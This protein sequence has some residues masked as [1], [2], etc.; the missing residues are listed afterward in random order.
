MYTVLCKHSSQIKVFWNI[1]SPEWWNTQ[2]G[3]SFEWGNKFT[4]PLK[5]LAVIAGASTSSN[6]NVQLVYKILRST[7]AITFDPRELLPRFRKTDGWKWARAIIDAIE[8]AEKWE[9]K[10]V[11]FEKGEYSSVN[12]R[13]YEKFIQEHP[14]KLDFS[15]LDGFAKLYIESKDAKSFTAPTWVN[16]AAYMASK[17]WTIRINKDTDVFL[18]T[19]YTKTLDAQ[20]AK[21]EEIIKP[22]I[23]KLW[24]NS[25]QLKLL[26]EKNNLWWKN[27]KI[28]FN[29]FVWTLEIKNLED[30]KT[31]FKNIAEKLS[32]ESAQ[33]LE[34]W[35]QQLKDG[36]WA[37]LNATEIGIANDVT[38][39]WR[40]KSLD[41][42]NIK[43]WNQDEIQAALPRI[44]NKIKSIDASL[45]IETDPLKIAELKRRQS[46]LTGI[47]E[48]LVVKNEWLEKAKKAAEAKKVHTDAT[49]YTR[50]NPG[51]TTKNL[52]EKLQTEKWQ[53]GIEMAG[54]IGLARTEKDDAWKDLPKI[55]FEE[56]Q[57]LYLELEKKWTLTKEEEIRK[58]EYW[59]IIDAN[60]NI[61]RVYYNTEAVLWKAE[62]QILFTDTNR[63]VSKNPNESYDFQALEK[64]AIMT[65]PEASAEMKN[66]YNLTSEDAP[67]KLS[68][69]NDFSSGMNLGS[70]SLYA[71]SAGDGMVYLSDK[72]WKPILDIKLLPYQVESVKREVLI[73]QSMGMDALIPALPQMKNL[74]PGS[75]RVNGFDGEL[76]DGEVIR[77]IGTLEKLVSNPEDELFLWSI[78]ERITHMRSRASGAGRIPVEYYTNILH[79]RGMLADDN[80]IRIKSLSDNIAA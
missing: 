22:V 69:E 62:A 32:K 68:S 64:V 34:L 74:I 24:K 72:E 1:V 63:F 80:S 61:A 7:D 40:K 67:L 54:K 71:I 14:W 53:K 5:A 78:P 6:P 59:A 39:M 65:D 23:E 8:A 70:T 46:L 30:F 50:E 33:L 17:E 29:S 3:E 60:Q 2:T 76:S 16:I 13:T 45:K 26:L 18:R 25:P 19:L 77:L 12:L 42:K 48:A 47:L 9:I 27:G 44:E 52:I 31:I 38:V 36:G 57:R 10:I 43:D 49:K 20:T 75:Y 11:V 79:E 56:A 73:F 41:S 51:W 66:L 28:D 21:M 37:K 4:D 35:N 55:W 15:L 58:R